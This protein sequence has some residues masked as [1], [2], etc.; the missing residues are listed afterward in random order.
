M[1]HLV[2]AVLL[3]FGGTLD[4][5]GLHWSTQMALAFAAAGIELERDPLDRAF[6]AADRILEATEEVEEMGLEAH[7]TLQAELMLR[8]L[9]HPIA[10][11][12]EI[13]ARFCGRARVHLARSRE[14]LAARRGAL[15]FALVSNF[16]PNLSRILE[17]EGLGEL[18]DVT[19]CSERVGVRKPDPEIFLLALE[20]LGETPEQAAMIG[21]SL[22]SDI[23]PA[24][25][26][27]L[28]TVWIRGDRVFGAGDERA[29]DEIV[30]D[31][32]AGLDCLGAGSEAG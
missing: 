3:D 24:K 25:E 16:T 7:V 30:A 27:G 11:A 9:G 23:M 13:A 10:P 28:T 21:D 6:L 31:L 1:K 32:A 5:E 29:A 8:E 15:R 14:L 19:V 22:P 2:S 4:S 18:I 20:A 26:L 12:P 17:E